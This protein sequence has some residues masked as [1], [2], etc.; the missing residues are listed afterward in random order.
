TARQPHRPERPGRPAARRPPR[1]ADGAAPARAQRRALAG[2]PPQRLPA[3][4]PRVPGHHPP[5]HHPRPRRSHHLHPR[6][7][8]RTARPAW[9]PPRRPR[10]GTTPRGDQRRAALPTRRHPADHLPARRARPDL[11]TIKVDLSEIWG[12]HTNYYGNVLTGSGTRNGES[13]QPWQG[14]DPTAK[15]RHWAI[16]G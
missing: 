10:P 4:R 13:G 5:D 7:H 12:W 1:P 14:F 3:R 6:R 2:H 8:H 11:T 15:N 9:R 16:P